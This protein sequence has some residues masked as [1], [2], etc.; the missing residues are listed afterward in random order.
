MAQATYF[1]TCAPGIEPLLHGE[2]K[3][4]KLGRVE[5]Q[6]GGVKF[7]GSQQDAWRVNLWL[8]TAVRVLMRVARFPAS[9]EDALYAGA[10]EVDWTAYLRS[11]ST[12]W[13]DCQCKDSTLTHS[14]FIAQRVKDAI[15]DQLRTRG[16]ERPTIQREAA[17]LRVHVHLSRDRCTLS[18]DTSGE[19]LHRRGWRQHQGKAPLGE[20]RIPAT[21]GVVH[22]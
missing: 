17:A 13:I 22:H 18:L 11:D 5:R 6:V 12:L 20:R 21:V 1:V 4:L 10:R 19:S 3:A 14:R 16:M 8:R 9:S 15:C 7:F 2:I